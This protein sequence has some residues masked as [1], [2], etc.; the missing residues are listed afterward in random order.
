MGNNTLWKFTISSTCVY[1]GISYSTFKVVFAMQILQGCICYT[2]DCATDSFLFAIIMHLCGQLELL[3]IRFAEIEK[4]IADRNH[5]RKFLGSWIRRH[6]KLILLAKNIEESF[7]LNL[8]IRLS[9]STIFIAVSG[10]T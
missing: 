7:N 6:Y 5:Y 10:I 9:I 8:L 1:K 2:A 4:K 3:K